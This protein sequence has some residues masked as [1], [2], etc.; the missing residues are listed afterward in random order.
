MENEPKIPTP[1]PTNGSQW[2]NNLVN[3]VYVAGGLAAIYFGYIN[4]AQTSAENQRNLTKAQADLAQSQKDLEA[5]KNRGLSFAIQ[6]RKIDSSS[7]AVAFEQKMHLNKQDLERQSKDLE[8]EKQE[9]DQLYRLEK[10]QYLKDSIARAEKIDQQNLRLKAEEKENKSLLEKE[11]KDIVKRI[12]E[13]NGN[14]ESGAAFAVLLYVDQVFDRKTDSLTIDKRYSPLTPTAVL[15][16]LLQKLRTSSSDAEVKQI[17]RLL[18]N[19]ESEKKYHSAIK[20]VENEIYETVKKDLGQ[21]LLEGYKNRLLTSTL[22]KTNDTHTF[23]NRAI[24]FQY[25]ANAAPRGFESTYIILGHLGAR[26]A[27]LIKDRGLVAL[28]ENWSIYADDLPRI[29]LGK[30]LSWL[31]ANSE[32]GKKKASVDDAEIASRIVRIRGNFNKL[33]SL[34]NRFG[35]AQLQFHSLRHDTEQDALYKTSENKSEISLYSNVLSTRL[36]EVISH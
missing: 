8:K 31:I 6:M 5:E 16:I 36:I 13:L 35:Y 32:L 27:G 25:L 11:D 2:A 7:S 21:L 3:V 14:T 17:G 20:Q 18:D 4:L 34:Y 24:I 30:E 22:K 26:S 12:V 28:R 19:Y 10:L 33:L 29:M 15:N 9:Y 23:S 1:S